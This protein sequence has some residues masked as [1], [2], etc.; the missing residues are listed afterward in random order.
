MYKEFSAVD[1]HVRTVAKNGAA[2]FVHEKL[3]VAG[4]VPTGPTCRP[5]RSEIQDSAD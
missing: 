5:I 4:G 2:T 1:I 3:E